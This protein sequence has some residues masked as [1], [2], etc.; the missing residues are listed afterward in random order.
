MKILILLALTLLVS[1]HAD[2]KKGVGC[3]SGCNANV[4]GSLK[5]GWYYSW[6]GYSDVQTVA[7]FVPMCFSGARVNQIPNYSDHLLGFNEPDHPDQSNMNV[8]YALS[9]WPQLVAKSYTI[10]SP[11]TASNPAASG[12]W[13]EQFMKGGPK[14]DYVA[15]HWYGG[16]EA[17]SF[18]NRMQEIYSKF[19]KP[20][21]I[22]EFA[23]QTH[24]DSVANPNK[25][26]QS[27]V[28]SF[29]DTVIPWMQGTSWIHRYCWHN[30]LV[31][32]SALWD[33][34]GQITATGRKYGSF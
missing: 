5:A 7:P 3:N 10:A 2:V 17:S 18:K 24:S 6:G 23:C 4:I 32:T 30:S 19:Q 16:A 33:A 27:Q 12:S 9:L 31:G 20:L 13:L 28:D 29:L 1:V 14:V 8:S 25:Y 21:W 15:V 26:T 11:A 22:T 34:N